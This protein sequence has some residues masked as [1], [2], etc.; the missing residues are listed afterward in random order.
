MIHE[1]LKTMG[2]QMRR[3]LAELSGLSKP[4]ATFLALSMAALLGV[5]DYATGYDF[6]LT[7]F[8]LVPICWACWA[9]GRKAGLFLATACAAIFWVADLMAGHPYKHPLIPFWNALML[10]ALYMGTVYILTACLSAFRSIREG[11]SRFRALFTQS[12]L[13][14]AQVRTATVRLVRVNDRF[15]AILGHLPKPC[16]SATLTSVVQECL[17]P[18]QG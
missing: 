10:L 13:G 18:V 15:C 4:W 9:A 12:L 6:Y 8:Y 11:E 16:P 1:H 17:Q 5:V 3:L 2:F 7:A 14:V